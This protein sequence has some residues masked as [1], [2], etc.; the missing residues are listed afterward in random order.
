L[1]LEIRG[2]LAGKTR[3]FPRAASTGFM[4]CGAG[5]DGAGGVSAQNERDRIIGD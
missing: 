3:R 1:R 5:G 4:A 2:V